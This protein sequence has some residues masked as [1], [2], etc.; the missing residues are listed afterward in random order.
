MSEKKKKKKKKLAIAKADRLK[1][2]F[3]KI[4]P[5]SILR[6]IYACISLATFF[7]TSVYRTTVFQIVYYH[8]MR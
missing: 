8:F 5:L 4:F 2:H 7:I 6:T 3:F 1:F